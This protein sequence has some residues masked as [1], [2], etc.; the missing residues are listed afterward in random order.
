MPLDAHETS[1]LQ[2]RGCS[3]VLHTWRPVAQQPIGLAVVFHG[4]AAHARYPTVVYAAEVLVGAG[5]VVCA[6]DLP[7]HGESEGQRAFVPSAP[8]AIDDAV[9]ALEA[10]RAMHAGLPTILVG[11]SMG[12]ALSVQVS[13][14]APVDGLVLLAPMLAIKLSP[15]LLNVL[16]IL[17]YSPISRLPLIASNSTS[18]RAQYADP[19]RRDACVNDLLAY[20]GKM[21]PATAYACVD[22]ARDTR[23]RLSEVSVPFLLLLAGN[24][25]VVDNCGA[26][27][28]ASNAKTPQEERCVRRFEGALHGLLCEPQPRRGE[29]EAAIAE[30]AVCRVKGG[31]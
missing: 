19:D 2:R 27:E 17:S 20:S 12:G 30:W 5:F 18:P 13:L 3:C 4:Y 28:L 15:V 29:I 1:R 8:A 24:E 10:A 9:A 11:S 25:H 14:R 21:H 22:L 31:P 7:G 23:S 6:F 26:D 16:W